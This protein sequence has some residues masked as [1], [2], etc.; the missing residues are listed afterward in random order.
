MIIIIVCVCRISSGRCA[1]HLG[2]ASRPATLLRRPRSI[3]FTT[4]LNRPSWT[5]DR[6]LPTPHPIHPPLLP[7]R[8]HECGICVRGGVAYCVRI[9]T[10]ENEAVVSTRGQHKG[11]LLS[12][13]DWSMTRAG[14]LMAEPSHPSSQLRLSD[15]DYTRGRPST[16]ISISYFK[17][18]EYFV[19]FFARAGIS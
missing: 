13:Y 7:T 17:A 12:S 2:A 18:T 4:A 15:C 14:R 1:V 16:C 3:S 19:G 5:E 11:L 8:V 6:T 9:V 10:Q